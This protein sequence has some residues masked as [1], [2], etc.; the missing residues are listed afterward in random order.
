MLSSTT[1][2]GILGASLN[3]ATVSRLSSDVDSFRIVQPAEAIENRNFDAN[4]FFEYVHFLHHF[5]SRVLTSF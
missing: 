1:T 2:T 5:N 4:A 3:S